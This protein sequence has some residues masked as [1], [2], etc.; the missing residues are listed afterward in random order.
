MNIGSRSAREIH[1]FK[2]NQLVGG[3]TTCRM[4]TKCSAGLLRWKRK[5]C[6][7]RLFFSSKRSSWTT[8]GCLR[9]LSRIF[10]EMC[11]GLKGSTSG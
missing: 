7:E 4:R 8:L 10:S 5:C 11:A 1:V 3:S 6:G 9:S 2:F